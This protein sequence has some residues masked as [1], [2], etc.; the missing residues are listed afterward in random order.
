MKLNVSVPYAHLGELPKNTY[1][2]KSL[3]KRIDL[4]QNGGPCKIPRK[5]FFQTRSERLII[6]HVK[7]Y[8]NRPP[9]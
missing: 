3:G 2:Y 9:L 8:I 1:F 6:I 5:T 7:E 4:F